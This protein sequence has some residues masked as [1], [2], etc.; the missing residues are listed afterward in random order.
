M[1]IN[2]NL[3]NKK[4][5]VIGGG[6]EAEKRIKSLL[7]QDCKIVIISESV[8][9]KIKKIIKLNKIKFLNQ[10]IQNM[11]FISETKPDIIITTTDNKNLNQKII[12]TAKKR[13]IIVYSSDNPNDSDFANLSVMDFDKTIQI[14]IFTGGQ[15]PAMAKKIRIKTEKILKEIITNHDINQ[16]KIQ[17]FAR[18]LAKNEILEQIKRKEY[19]NSVMDDKKIDQL[20]KDGQIKKAENRAVILL[21]K[22]K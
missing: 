22:W 7:G 14:A 6:N 5:I 15:S 2:L 4:V 3:K 12:K 18:H 11:K 10:K 13:K 16:I 9:D 8:N 17:N 20:I 21:R 1:I 19:L